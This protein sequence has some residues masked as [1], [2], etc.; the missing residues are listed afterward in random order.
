MLYLQMRFSVTFTGTHAVSYEQCICNLDG[1]IQQ[2]IG[3]CFY[4]IFRAENEIRKSVLINDSSLF[5]ALQQLSTDLHINGSS[6]LS[7]LDYG[8]YLDGLL[9]RHTLFN[10]ACQRFLQ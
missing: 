9:Y 5:I 6:Q 1:A 10:T 2:Q 8:A 4:Y 7:Q 3:S